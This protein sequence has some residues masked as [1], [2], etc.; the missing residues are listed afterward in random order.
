ML[1]ILRLLQLVAMVVW[2]GGLIFFA[3]VL[4][5]TAFQTLP[6]FHLAGLVVGAALKEFHAIGL[7][8]G[9]IFLV[10]TALLFRR[11]PMR[12]RGRYEMELLL[13]GVMVLATLYL[14]ANVLPAMDRDQLA[15]GGD[16]NTATK[17]NPARTNF[18]TLH[19][20]SEQVEGLVLLCGLAVV[21]L[22]SREHARVEAAA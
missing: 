10:T 18:D 17:D 11:A 14:Q 4:A 3:F 6:T 13:T 12:I 8:C 5:P 7:A 22:L 15:V 9:G 1:G 21:F 20:R 19:K 2:V 16:I